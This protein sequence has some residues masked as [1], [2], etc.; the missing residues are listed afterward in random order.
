MERKNLLRESIVDDPPSDD[1]LANLHQLLEYYGRIHGFMAGHLWEASNILKEAVEE[2]RLR[3][4]SFTANIVAS[5]LRGLL[6]KLVRDGL[7]NLVITTCGT[8]D[9]DIAKSR[10]GVY[11]KGRFFLDDSLLKKMEIHRLGNILVPVESYGPVVEETVKEAFEKIGRNRVSGYE[12]LWLVGSLI[13][14]DNSI[15]KVAY[16]RRVP[17]IVPGYYDGSFG[18]N[19]YIYSRLK[20]VDIDLSLDEKLLDDTFFEHREDRAMALIIGGGIS[21]HHTIWWSQFRG[22]LDYAVYVT[23]AVEYDGSLSGAHPREAVSWGKIKP[24][25]KH[26]VVYGD[27]T[28]I[29][30]LLV[31]A[32]YPLKK[33]SLASSGL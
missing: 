30:P 3:V 14:D 24:S 17:I 9:H 27:A 19:T 20:G 11:Y 15:L 7:F 31:S 18:T 10:G 1:L 25:S 33:G 13:E 4:L 2:S 5:G 21:K 12:L 32:L 8:I 29:L 28:L 26:T 6:A 22:G 16:E 23:T